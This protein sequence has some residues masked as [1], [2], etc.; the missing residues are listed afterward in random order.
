MKGQI[1]SILGFLGHI[2]S[3]TITQ[4]CKCRHRQCIKMGMVIFPHNFIHKIGGTLDLAH[5]LL[6]A[7]CLDSYL[8]SLEKPLYPYSFIQEILQ[9]M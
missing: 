8:L 3:V 2:V 1:V 6:L 5:V 7:L 4:F 9:D